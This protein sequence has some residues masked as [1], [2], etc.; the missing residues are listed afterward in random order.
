MFRHDSQF[1]SEA[2]RL[3]TAQKTVSHLGNIKVKKEYFDKYDGIHAEISQA[4]RFDE[5]TYLSTIFLGKT[6]ITRDQINKAEEKFPISGQRYTHGK[7]L[8]NTECSILRDTGVSKSY[9]SIS[10]Y[11]QCK[12]FY[13]LPK[14]TSTM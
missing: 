4:T 7:L 9:M 6:D 2:I 13:T 5:S 14:F 3:P 1:D 12:S 10:Y 8:D 11:M